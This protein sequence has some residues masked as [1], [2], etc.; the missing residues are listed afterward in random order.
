MARVLV[1]DDEAAMRRL[2]LRILTGEG[3]DVIEA[4]SGPQGLHEFDKQQPDV[5]IV[6][7]LMPETDG[8][9]VIQKMLRQQPGLGIIAISGGGTVAPDFY[10][11]LA[12]KFG[13]RR[14]LE[15]P[16]TAAALIEAVA[17]LLNPPVA[18]T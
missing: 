10:L 17:S 12:G 16:F 6:D 4:A 11:D 2:I 13:A 8:I 14:Y 7:I 18:E 3:H 9:E 1:I 5:V 15:K